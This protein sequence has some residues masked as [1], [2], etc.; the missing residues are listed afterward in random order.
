EI[1]VA[2]RVARAVD[3]GALA[4]PDAEDTVVTA[5]ATELGLLGAPQRGRGEVLVDSRLE[6]NVRGAEGLCRTPKLHVE[7]AQ[8]RA[9]IA[10]DVAGRA[11][12]D[13]RVAGRLH[14]RQADDRLRSGDQD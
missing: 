5:V 13:A 11:F 14:Q 10:G 2:E 9:A 3:P 8:R 6:K 1:G 12:A 7:P 4:I